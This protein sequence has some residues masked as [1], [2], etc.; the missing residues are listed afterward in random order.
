LKLNT[1]FALFLIAV[2]ASLAITPLVRRLCERF[3]LF[4]VPTDGRRVHK[5]AIPRLGG[6]AVYAGVILALSTLPLVDNFLTQSLREHKA[7][8][9]LTLIP[10]TLVLLLGI[11]D[12]LRGTNAV[13]KFIGLGLIASLF[14]ALGGR[15]EVLKI[16]LV[17]TLHFPSTVSFIVTVV[18]MVGIANAFNLIDGMDG[19]ASGAALFSSLV[20]L[21]VSLGNG[22]HLPIVVTLVL[23][24]SLAGFLRYNFNPAS[25]FLGD[26]GALFV[27]F[28]LAALSVLGTQKATTAVAVITPILAFG[29]PVVDTG[30]TLARRL[31][32]GK[33]IFQGDKEHI[34]HMLLA[35]G[36][37][38]RHVVLVLYGVCAG[39]GL[40]A[41]IF[42]KTS[43][44]TTGL[45]LF[46]IVV[47]V[48]FAVG[49]L[50]YH[51]V[52]EIKAGVKRNVADR[53]IRV[54]NNIRVRRA[55][56]ALSKAASLD[57]LLQAVGEMLEFGEFAAAEVRLG[58]PG[59]ADDNARALKSASSARF[60]KGA[61]LRNGRI[62]WSW[63]RTDIDRDEI[64]GSRRF[65]SVRLP[66]GTEQSDW[67]WI[68]LYR[69]FDAEP[70]LVDI[71]Y[72]CDLFRQELSEAAERIFRADEPRISSPKL[73]MSVSA[74]KLSN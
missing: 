52:D 65:W 73:G 28:T 61:E 47:A 29:L 69:E 21:V 56:L 13:T 58:K 66:L 11:Y 4:D 68:N 7:E 37:S 20:M 2:C 36:W 42:T 35:R 5:K 38:Q 44:P 15:I 54:A 62:A 53:R 71:N 1:Y 59:N 39:F 50:R 49:H 31:V 25:I 33:P 45:C 48:I 22:S 23:C 26:S 74:G 46:V 6:L 43:S 24:G 63:S 41:A 57:E 34:H 8:I 9:V 12:D 60:A 18:W 51:E 27:G 17:G 30:V 32:S 67:G 3:K 64:I 40:L 16:P 10:A 55:S 19:L 70:L 14:Y 72:L